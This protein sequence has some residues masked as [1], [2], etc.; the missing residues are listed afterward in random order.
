ML[1][2]Q[3]TIVQ[4]GVELVIVLL[5]HQLLRVIIIAHRDWDRAHDHRDRYQAYYFSRS[6]DHYGPARE[7]LCLRDKVLAMSPGTPTPYSQ[8]DNLLR[9]RFPSLLIPAD[10]FSLDGGF[11]YRFLPREA[12]GHIADIGFSSHTPI[13]AFSSMAQWATRNHPLLAP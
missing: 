1:P 8:P 11:C 13:H 10:R 7:A 2:L 5:G 3:I 4:T 9:L 12:F 6:P